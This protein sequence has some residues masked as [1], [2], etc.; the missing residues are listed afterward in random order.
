MQGVNIHDL[1]TVHMH[2]YVLNILPSS[3]QFGFCTLI[4]TR[5]DSQGNSSIS[6][7]LV[8]EIQ[9]LYVDRW[10]EGTIKGL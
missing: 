4:A 9:Q 5:F 1:C 10:S 7:K 3:L 6:D 2:F 8:K